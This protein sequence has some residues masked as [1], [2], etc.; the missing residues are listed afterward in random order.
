MNPSGFRRLQASTAF[1][2]AVANTVVFAVIVLAL[3]ALLY[4]LSRE[5]VLAQIDSDIS[6]DSQALL[7]S[8]EDG[9]FPGL[10]AALSRRT[11]GDRHSEAFYLVV[12]SNGRRLAGN[13]PL[14][15]APRGPAWVTVSPGIVPGLEDG[16]VRVQVSDLTGGG[17]LLVG[18][19]PQRL[20]ELEDIFRAGGLWS[21]LGILLFGLISGYLVSRRVL[22]GIEQIAKGA[23]RIGAGDLSHRLPMAK[24]GPEVAAIGAAVN[25][26]LDRIGILT[27]NLRQVTDDIAHD[28]RTPLGR[29]RQGLDRAARSARTTDDFQAAI[30]EARSECDAIIGTFNALLRIAQLE[31]Q[32]PHE[33]FAEVDLGSL[34]S[35]LCEAYGPSAEDLGYEL[36]V[37]VGAG[38]MIDGDADVLVQ[39]VS[40]LIENALRYA[41]SGTDITVSV[42]GLPTGARIVVAD[43]GPGILEGQRERVMQ[44]FVR[45]DPTRGTPGTGLGLAL[46]RA[47]ADLHGAKL[48]LEDNAPGLRVVL[49]FPTKG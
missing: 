32:D 25:T 8:E 9:G 7:A 47:A 11:E 31:A 38:V 22:S 1:R 36:I 37:D 18:R 4:L 43:G 13:L 41:L 17:S 23:A 28:L 33:G 45:L 46:V 16:L 3:L 5:R 34:V 44:R 27:T 2:V 40:N 15:S 49:E 19:S 26:M 42:T 24:G 29:L 35:R 14:L 6:H 10:I 12:G 20:D 48:R 30:H 39:M 21:G